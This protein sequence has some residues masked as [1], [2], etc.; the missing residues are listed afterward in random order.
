MKQILLMIAVVALVA[1]VGCGE[2][3]SPES[4]AM[5]K[6]GKAR[7]PPKISEVHGRVLSVR[8]LAVSERRPYLSWKFKKKSK[9]RFARLEGLRFKH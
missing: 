2:K 5:P 9:P 4:Q 6:A 3:D 8:A 7:I 1:L